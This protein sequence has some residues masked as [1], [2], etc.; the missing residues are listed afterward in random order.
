VPQNLFGVKTQL[1]I[2]KA[3]HDC[4]PLLNEAGGTFGL[5]TQMVKAELSISK[6]FR[7]DENRHFSF[8]L[9]LEEQLRKNG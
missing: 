5:L 6:A 9:S 3:K 8:S 7:Y 2:W 4:S 1:S